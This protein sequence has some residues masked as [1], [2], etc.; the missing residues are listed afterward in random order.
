[1]DNTQLRAA[2]VEA[3]KRVDPVNTQFAVLTGEITNV[4]LEKGFV[5]TTDYF[6]RKYW[7]GINLLFWEHIISG[8]LAI[9]LNKDNPDHP[10]FRITKFGAK[11]LEDESILV[12][13]PTGTIDSIKKQIDGEIDPVVREYF[14]EALICFGRGCLR[15]ATVMVGVAAEKT[16]YNLA[17]AFLSYLPDSE[18]K[19][20]KEAVEKK[21]SVSKIYDEFRKIIETRKR[22]IQNNIGR[23][24]ILYQM[25]SMF[26]MIRID[27]NDQGHPKGIKPNKDSVL[28]N[29]LLFPQLYII[30]HRLIG[31][32]EKG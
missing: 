27:R 11:M 5:D 15:A 22:D 2:F 8:V 6:H 4:A 20:F 25:D 29:L 26:N 30:S 3:L 10:F 19:K 7:D 32:F 16:F 13:D 31:F 1:M 9:G 12:Y 14:G 21:R 23:D 18:G 24:D 17:D 28:G